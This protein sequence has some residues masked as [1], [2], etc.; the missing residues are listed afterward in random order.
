MPQ[1]P[2]VIG[3][4]CRVSQSAAFQPGKVIAGV[5]KPSWFQS[6]R[7]GHGVG[8]CPSASAW[9]AQKQAPKMKTHPER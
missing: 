3:N 1:A 8:G 4:S 9:L 5:E 6:A 7:P 2:W